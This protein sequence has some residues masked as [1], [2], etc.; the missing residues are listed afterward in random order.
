MRRVRVRADGG[1]ELVF[2]VMFDHFIRPWRLLGFSTNV[3]QK[4]VFNEEFLI[5]ENHLQPSPPP[6]FT[7]SLLTRRNFKKLKRRPSILDLKSANVHSFLHI[8]RE[9]NYGS[10]QRAHHVAA[11]CDS[12][13]LQ[14]SRQHFVSAFE[15]LFGSLKGTFPTSGLGFYNKFLILVWYTL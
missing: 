3:F 7:V 4:I 15:E 5:A 11:V 8:Q 10:L 14:L 13:L 2:A 12:V 6:F 9:R 1:V